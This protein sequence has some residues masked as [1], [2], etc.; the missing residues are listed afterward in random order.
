MSVRRS[1]FVIMLLCLA[2]VLQ[3]CG[4]G[5]GGKKNQP[6]KITTYVPDQKNYTV[7]KGHEVAFSVTASDPDGD[8]LAYQWSSTAGGFD[9]QKNAAST[10][11]TAPSSAGTCTVTVTVSD[12]KDGV[13]SHTWNITVT[14]QEVKKPIIGNAKPETSSTNRYEINANETITLSISPTDPQGLDLTS[15][16]N[17]SAGTLADRKLDTVKWTAPDVPGDATV[18]VT[19]SNGAL[20]AT[21]TFYFKVKGNVVYVTDN[22]TQVQTWAAGNIYVIEDYEEI[23]V[24]ST[25]TVS[26]GAIVKLG[27]DSS[28]R[29]SGSGRIN[30]TGTA[31]KPIIF[32]SLMDDD[33]GG[34][35]NQDQDATKGEAGS[36]NGVFLDG[37]QT[38]NKFV[39]CEFY[40]GGGGFAGSMLDLDDTTDTQVVNCTFAFSKGIAL[41]ASSAQGATIK[42]NVFYHNEKPLVINVDT[43]LD[44]SNTFHNPQ[45]P[46]EKNEYQGI[47][48]DPDVSN[49]F[50]KT[51]KWEETEAAF[52][53]Q[54]WYFQVEPAGSLILGKGTTLKLDGNYL[55]VYGRLQAT[56][57]ETQKIVI[58]SIYDDYYGGSSA[59]PN[60][61][62][63]EAGDWESIYIDNGGSAEFD[64]CIVR[65]GGTS[66]SRDAE[67]AA[68]YDAHDSKGTKIQNTVFEYNLRGLDLLSSKSTIA[69][70]TFR[71]NQYPLRISGDIDTDDTLN[72]ADNTYNAI[73]M[74]GYDRS[75]E[76]TEPTVKMVHTKVPYVLLA[77][78]A[79]I[80][81][82]VE[83]GD[84]TVVMAWKDVQVDLID[85]ASFKN[86]SKAVFTSFR[87]TDR[88]GD[89]GGG[90]EAAKNDDWK[91][92]YDAGLGKWIS[93]TNIHHAKYPEPDED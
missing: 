81:S 27:E 55:Y 31:E 65:Y 20:T 13:T 85:G 24:Q 4:G 59:G 68:L 15:T 19:V 50:K 37:S 30:A 36:W 71:L 67:E 39:Y 34:D 82:E 56:G 83:L 16:W 73:Y 84:G 86:F 22:I 64:H 8:T 43:N 92:I 89:V 91:G 14:D 54:G 78:T 12:G 70:S 38:Q 87:D 62:T 18:T 49:E 21:H 48:V 2:L 40:Y 47:F 63:A 33:H 44:D 10:T 3:G 69:N 17:C 5:G 51:T 9:G 60:S 77:D 79:L 28:L 88:G 72:I 52:V 90:S 61:P 80:G 23:L 26:P 74:G 57:T 41:D 66:E 11:W 76:F 46:S 75:V 1:L 58:T 42:A 29:T 32:T 53:L 6:P 25:L 45:S 93:G 35:T 7:V